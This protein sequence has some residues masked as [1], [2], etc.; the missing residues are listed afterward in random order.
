M[1]SVIAS[2]AAIAN[3]APLRASAR[4]MRAA[5]TPKVQRAVVAAVDADRV[6]TRRAV[7]ASLVAAPALLKA[8]LAR[9]DDEEAVAAAPAEEAP[10]AAEE[11]PA[12]V[13]EVEPVAAPVPQGNDDPLAA[14]NAATRTGGNSSTAKAVVANSKPKESGG[15]G[16]AGV[17]GAVGLAGVGF[18]AFKAGASQPNDDGD[19]DDDVE[20]VEEVSAPEPVEEYYEEEEEE[21]PANDFAAKAAAAAAAASAAAATKREEAAEA[22]AERKAAAAEAKAAKAAAAATKIMTRPGN[23][24]TQIERREEPAPAPAFSART[25]RMPSRDAAG[26]SDSLLP[27]GFPSAEDLAACETAEEKEEV[28]DKA[29]LLVERLEAKA[30]SAERFVDG[31]IVGFFGFLRPNA[32]RNAEKARAV[33]EEAASAAAALRKSAKPGPSGAVVGGAIAA[34]VAAGAA[35]LLGGDAIAP[36]GGA[37]GAPKADRPA[38]VSASSAAKPGLFAA[39]AVE[40]SK[41]P[42]GVE[43]AQL[44]AK[45][46]SGEGDALAAYEAL[47]RK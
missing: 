10:A 11:T 17:V 19:D 20:Y 22:L 42:Y 40:A 31:P 38:R 25:V 7:V 35:L 6:A 46:N 16:V 36:S 39:P 4:A 5:A 14:Y 27:R 26:D 41:G 23:E 33:A 37:A 15:G 1:S 30:D 2:S 44:V 12:A 8:S 29:D 9:A 43:A 24:G 47:Q 28:C 32:E 45:V 3:A 34:V 13:E 21:A 18:A